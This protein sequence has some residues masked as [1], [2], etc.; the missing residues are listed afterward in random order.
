MRACQQEDGEQR[1]GDEREGK[2]E[3]PGV[4]MGINLEG[5]G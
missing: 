4:N 3:K 2:E 5:G 1:E